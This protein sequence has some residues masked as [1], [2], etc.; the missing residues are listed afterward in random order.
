MLGA[1]TRTFDVIGVRGH[2]KL[3]PTAIQLASSDP[4]DLADLAY[5]QW[6]QLATRER[7][8]QP[9]PQHLREGAP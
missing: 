4:P 2:A 6:G 1:A 7:E 8:E 5:P 3:I 9:A